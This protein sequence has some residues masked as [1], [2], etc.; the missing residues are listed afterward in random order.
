[1]IKGAVVTGL[2]GLGLV[3]GAGSVV[4][5]DDGSATVKIKDQRV[6]LGGGAGGKMYSCP[7]GTKGKLSPHD[8]R[9][10]RI[11]LPLRQVR[12]QERKIDKQYP[13]T[14]APRLIASRYN[15]LLRRHKRLI[16]AYNT[17]VDRR[18]AILEADCV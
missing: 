15:G 7:P 11:T 5:D 6:R 10:G 13:G 16:A 18:N 3:G 4:Y 2:V 17:S 12:R 8:I 9:A 1:M 14:T